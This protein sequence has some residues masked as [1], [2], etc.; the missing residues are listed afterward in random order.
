MTATVELAGPATA[1]KLNAENLITQSGTAIQ[2][3]VK[4]K[5]DNRLLGSNCYI[6]SN[7]S[8]MVLNLTTG[9]TAPPPTQST[10]CG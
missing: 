8:P 10:D 9:A 1:I 4:V 2:M 6:G 5:L 3:P 7:S